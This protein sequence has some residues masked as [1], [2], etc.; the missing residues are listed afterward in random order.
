MSMLPHVSVRTRRGL[1]WTMTAMVVGVLAF[2]LVAHMGQNP[3]VNAGVQLGTVATRA[4]TEGSVREGALEDIIGNIIKGALSIAGVIFF[5]YIVWAGYLWMT[6][7]GEE[8][9]ITQ[10]KKMISGAIIGLA[11]TLMAYAITIFVVGRLTSPDTGA[12]Q[13]PAPAAPAAP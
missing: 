10:A 1:A 12:L 6:A 2:P 7:H 11:I 9:K 8:E 4:G 3:F 13:N 5:A